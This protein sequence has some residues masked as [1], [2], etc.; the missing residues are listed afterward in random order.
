MK[1]STLFKINI[2]I[3]SLV[4]LQYLLYALGLSSEYAE[5]NFLGQFGAIGFLLSLALI[6]SAIIFGIWGIIAFLQ[7]ASKEV[8]TTN[9]NS[10][11]GVIRKSLIYKILLYAFLIYL[12]TTVM[13]LILSFF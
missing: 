5:W 2:V 12:T 1:K 4:A 3:W 9:D 8:N 6:P 10:K 7:S 13:V 11:K